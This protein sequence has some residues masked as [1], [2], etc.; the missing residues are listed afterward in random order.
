MSGLTVR[1]VRAFLEVAEVSHFGRAAAR[2][3]IAQPLLSQMMLRLE[4]V[5][6]TQLLVRRPAVRL[7]PAGEMFLPYARRVIEEL[8]SGVEVANKTGAGELG[9]LQLG[10]PTL[11]SLSWLPQAIADY[12]RA[13]TSVQ[14]TYLDLTTAGQL[15][16]LRAGLIDVGLIR[17]DGS[18][19]GD[20]K[21]IPIDRE[22]LLLAV[23]PG[24]RLAD[25]AVIEAR[26][27]AAEPFILFPRMT[28][29]A[30]FDSI[31]ED[32][33]R[34]GVQLNIAREGRDWLAVLGLVRAEAGISFV[35]QSLGTLGLSGLVTREV[36]GLAMTTTLS[37]AYLKSSENP[38][39]E[40]FV[41]TMAAA[42]RAHSPDTGK[43]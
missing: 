29:P 17:Q 14:V 3:D 37:L 24:H 12:Q 21:I 41:E 38:V 39:V 34:A 33:R 1:H 23:A 42:S 22:P 6:G 35:P 4:Q 13:Y 28:A 25:Q 10:F 26:D 8:Q 5:V 27:L 36:A 18:S 11:L 9:H 19:S 43:R 16:G 30:L 7:T 20:L 40:R 31:L 15:Q 32:A 2:L